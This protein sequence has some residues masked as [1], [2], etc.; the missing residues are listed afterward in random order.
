[1]QK[2]GYLY[3]SFSNNP[4]VNG[5]V[6]DV[7]VIFSK[8]NLSLSSIDNSM[9]GSSKSVLMKG[10]SLKPGEFLVSNSGEYLL[11]FNIDGTLNIGKVKLVNNNAK[12][13]TYTDD[14]SLKQNKI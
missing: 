5:I 3:T 9:E 6:S 11:N 2:K 13:D 1:M 10:E 7:V 12:L 4:R 14:K 8:T